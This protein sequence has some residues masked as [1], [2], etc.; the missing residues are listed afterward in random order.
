MVKKDS[1]GAIKEVRVT[2]V[3]N[4]TS[5]LAALIKVVAAQALASDKRMIFSENFSEGVTPSLTFSTIIIKW[6]SQV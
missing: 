4:R 2:L 6:D 3:V 1:K 5:S